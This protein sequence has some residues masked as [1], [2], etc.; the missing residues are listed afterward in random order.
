MTANEYQKL[1]L[2]T[3]N[4]LSKKEMTLNGALGL[5]GESGEFADHIKKNMFQGHDL[6]KDYMS[7][8]LGDIMWYVALACTSIDVDLEDVM[9]GNIEKLKKRFPNGFEEERSINRKD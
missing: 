8:E 1:A 9:I 4:M 2:T 5:C 6:D 3:A 7:K